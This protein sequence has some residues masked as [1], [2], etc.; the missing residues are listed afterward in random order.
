MNIP[1]PGAHFD[2]LLRQTRWHHVQ[3][4]TTADMKANMMLT[5]PALLITL[6]TRYV[7]EEP[8]KW[9]ALT[10]IGFCLVTIGLAAYAAMPKLKLKPASKDPVSTSN[11]S[12]NLLFFADFIRL[13]YPEYEEAME[14]VLSDPA[15]AY[16][17]Q[18]REL[19]GLGMYLAKRKFR[20]VRLA[21][22]SFIA[23]FIASGT[24]FVLTGLVR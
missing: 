2:Q 5:V 1:Q 14:E 8:F 17:A 20:F 18:V 11:P 6:T 22:V 24:V 3:L 16:E 10:L 19:Y 23:G 7:T 13:S 4:S 15:K 21:Y 12:F 9:A